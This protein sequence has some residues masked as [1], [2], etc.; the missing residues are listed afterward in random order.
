MVLRDLKQGERQIITQM[1]QIK[2]H[3]SY[4]IFSSGLDP[5][6]CTSGH[7]NGTSA[8]SLAQHLVNHPTLSSLHIKNAQKLVTQALA[9]VVSGNTRLTWHK[10]LSDLVQM[11]ISCNPTS[12]TAPGQVGL[13]IY[14]CSIYPC[15]CGSVNV[16][17]IVEKAP[18]VGFKFK[19]VSFFSL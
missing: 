2:Q 10:C 19:R 17:G 16:M 5:A 6:K 14:F 8:V 11:A 12:T 18:G 15:K 1:V 9:C 13:F 3:T 7:I 4:L